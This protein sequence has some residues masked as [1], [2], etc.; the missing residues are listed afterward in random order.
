M[1]KKSRKA[2]HRN[3]KQ[4]QGRNC[5]RISTFQGA[6][7]YDANSFAAIRRIV[8]GVTIVSPLGDPN[9]GDDDRLS[10]ARALARLHD[11]PH[12]A[13][14]RVEALCTKYFQDL[15]L[16]HAHEVH[17]M[18]TKIRHVDAPESTPYGTII[19]VF[20][21][22]HKDRIENG[23]CPIYWERMPDQAGRAAA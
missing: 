5:A 20:K 16:G 18:R 17:V 22:G 23:L 2:M 10:R 11:H 1:S 13:V 3:K 4:N 19:V 12:C 8:P 14:V 7:E 21:P 15:V 9:E 6:K